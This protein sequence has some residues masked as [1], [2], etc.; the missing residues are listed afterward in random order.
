MYRLFVCFFFFT[1]PLP[2]IHHW[3]LGYVKK[4][5]DEFSTLLKNLTAHGTVQYFRSL[6]TEFTNQF[7]NFNY[8][9]L[10]FHLPICAEHYFIWNPVWRLPAEL[11]RIHATTPLLHKNLD[12]Y[13]VHTL[14]VKSSTVPVQNFTSILLRTV[15]RSNFR[16]VGV[17]PCE[18]NT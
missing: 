4:A 7:Q 3:D 10:F 2:W 14:S 5:P 13:D 17:F 15:R 11:P 9:Q 16:T 8:F 18:W 12:G 6:D 1:G